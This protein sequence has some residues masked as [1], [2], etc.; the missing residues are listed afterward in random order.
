MYDF[1]IDARGDN[2]AVPYS[3]ATARA[4]NLHTWLSQLGYKCFTRFKEPLPES[5]FLIYTFWQA[6]LTKKVLKDYENSPIKF[7]FNLIGFSCNGSLKDSDHYNESLWFRSRGGSLVH[8]DF[9]KNGLENEFY[10]GIGIDDTMFFPVEKKGILIDLGIK[11]NRK[12]LD[13]RKPTVCIE[14]FNKVFSDCNFEIYACAD[15]FQDIKLNFLVKKFVYSTQKQFA[16]LLN[17]SQIFI[18]MQESLGMPIC[19]SQMSGTFPIIS[20]LTD[21]GAVISSKYF[22]IYNI[23]D[24]KDDYENIEESAHSLK[25]AVQ[26]ALKMINN[27]SSPKICQKIRKGALLK[28]NG[29]QYAQR[30]ADV[31]FSFLDGRNK[32]LDF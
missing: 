10:V 11:Q 15:T 7:F 22:S 14:M 5:K 4:Y 6:S 24:F 21:Q 3:F 31:C 2:P 16:D 17:A 25:R 27:E 13:W 8:R 12:K 28:F 29:I 9:G 18:C 26:Q 1:I 30:I 23:P 20:S 19:E 32:L